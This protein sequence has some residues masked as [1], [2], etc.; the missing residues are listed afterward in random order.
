MNKLLR[1]TIQHPADQFVAA[2]AEI[3]RPHAEVA[4]LRR[5]GC[6]LTRLSKD[7]E[8]VT[9]YTGFPSYATL[10]AFFRSIEPT[11]S[12]KLRFGN[13]DMELADMHV[14]SPLHPGSVSD[15]AIT[16]DKG[17]TIEGELAKVGATLVIPPFLTATRPQFTKQEVI[18][19]QAIVWV[20]VH[21]ECTIRRVKCYHFFDRVVPLTCAGSINQMWTVCCLLTNVRGSLLQTG[22]DNIDG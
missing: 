7:D 1:V 16:C 17:L 12:R 11:D 10:M 22:D 5:E 9:L 6:F 20:R 2:Q 4:S 19:T 3:V 15:N 21:V 18:D 14:V 13:I 8:L